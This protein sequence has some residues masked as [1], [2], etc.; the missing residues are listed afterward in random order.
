M[1][2]KRAN[3]E[4]SIGKYKDGW[5]SRI[6]IGY[7]EDG[8]PIRKEFYGKTQKEVKEKLEQF[9][10]Q[11]LMDHIQINDKTTVEEWFYTY[12]FEYK[13]NKNHDHP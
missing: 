1:A 5:R 2:N 11:Y 6:M 4:G 7:N 8:K 10:K 3:G 9:K 12:I 13:Q